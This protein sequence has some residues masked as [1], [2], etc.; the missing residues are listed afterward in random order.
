[1]TV[2]ETMPDGPWEFDAEVAEAFDDML[3]RS[4]P[5]Y[6]VMRRAVFDVSSK[7]LQ[8]HPDKS[9]RILDLGTSRGEAIAPLVRRFGAYASYVGVEVSAPMIDAAR[10]R[11]EDWSDYVEIRNFDLRTGFPAGPWH[12]IQS[13]LTLQFVPIEY[14]ERIVADAYDALA[15]GGALVIVEKVLGESRLD[16]L[17]VDLYYEMKAEAGYSTEQI[18]RKR[19]SL[20]GVLVPIT[21][22][23]NEDLLRK[24]GFGLVDCF[25][26]WMNFAAWVALKR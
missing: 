13:I 9:Y 19:L 24:A 20:E 1:M 8:A 17:F 15:P 21:A 23:W 2:D 12:V 4:I 10:S 5:Q 16:E 11:F 6:E 3:A 14:R 18:E 7:I 22:G 25:W 26:R